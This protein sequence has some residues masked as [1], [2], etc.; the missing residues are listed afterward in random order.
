MLHSRINLVVPTR[1][2][3]IRDDYNQAPN[4]IDFETFFRFHLDPAMDRWRAA[5]AA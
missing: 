2:K 1:I 4:V 3:A 5:G